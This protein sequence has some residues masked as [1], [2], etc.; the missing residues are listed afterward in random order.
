MTVTCAD[1]LICCFTFLAFFTGNWEFI[2]VMPIAITNLTEVSSTIYLRQFDRSIWHRDVFCCGGCARQKIWRTRRAHV[3]W[4]HWNFI[5][6]WQTTSLT[7]ICSCWF[8]VRRRHKCSEIDRIDAML[9][10]LTAHCRCS[11]SLKERQKKALCE[12]FFLFETCSLVWL[13]NT[14]VQL[15]QVSRA[16]RISLLLHRLLL[17]VQ[18]CTFTENSCRFFVHTHVSCSKSCRTC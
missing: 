11:S 8:E 7:A 17:C 15:A 3:F 5:W 1:N 14:H 12:S 18:A 6:A 10:R 9:S 2:W 13:G 16:R 4:L